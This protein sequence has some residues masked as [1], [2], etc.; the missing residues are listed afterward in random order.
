MNDLLY[1]NALALFPKFGPKRFRKLYSYFP[2]MQEA[3]GASYNQLKEAGIEEEIVSEFLGKRE[4]TDLEREWEKLEK[5]GIKIITIL[6]KNYPARLKE[7][8]NPPALLYLKGKLQKD[9]YS[10]AIV[11]TRKPTAYGRQ[12]VLEITSQLAQNGL[13]IVSGLALG[14]DGLAHQACLDAKGSTIAVLGGGID[15]KTL[16]PAKHQG[17]AEK[18]IEQ[19]G[20]VISEYPVGTVPLKQNFPYRNRIISGLSLGVL[21]IEAPEDSGALITARYALEQDREVFA[22]PGSIYSQNSLGPNN[23][24]KMGGKLV[25]SAADI[26]GE[27]NLRQAI[28]FI[29]AKKIVPDTKEEALILEHLSREPLHIDKLVELSKLNTALVNATLTIME[30]K[31][32]VKNL[33]GIGYVVAR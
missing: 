10:L 9:E 27:L 32:K 25:T 3:F 15:K 12:A 11:G 1:W 13:A 26:L 2:S 33:D 18:I 7:I 16:Y 8:Y 21:V 30:M 24:I 6:D 29:A 28:E 22:L 20:A 4:Q 5:E 19:G 14:I 17:L 31:G 23:L